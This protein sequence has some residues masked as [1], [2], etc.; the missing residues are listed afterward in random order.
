VGTSTGG[1]IFSLGI[2]YAG[3]GHPGLPTSP[4]DAHRV[5]AFFR[6]QGFDPAP[7]VQ[8]LS[9]A[10]PRDITDRVEEWV[11]DLRL[12]RPGSQIVVFL[13]G[14]GRVH[15]GSHYLLAATSPTGPPY[16][17]TKAVGAEELVRALLNSAARQVLIVLD[18]CHAGFAADQIQAAL[19]KARSAQAGPGIRLA[20][21][22]SCLHHESAYGGQF[23]DAML[24]ALATGSVGRFWADSD[25][26]V[27]PLELCD[28]LRRRLGGEQCALT[29]GNDGM[30]IIPNPLYR[31]DGADRPVEV[32]D[33]FKG[34]PAAEREHFLRKVAGVDPGDVG[35]FFTGRAT[36]SRDVVAWLA[37][38]DQGALVVTG[39]PGAGKSAFLGRLAVLADPD[40]QPAC[41]HLRLLDGDPATRPP[42]GVFDAVVH[43]KNTGVDATAQ[44]VA[45]QIGLDLGSSPAP[46]RDL[47]LALSEQRRRITVL[48]DALD[49]AEHGEEELIARDVLRA[50]AGLD[51]CR[52]IVGT[53]RDRD[54]R[55]QATPGDPGPLITALQ[56]RHGAF[57]VID[58]STD[59]DTDT[60]I[61][62][63]VHDRLTDLADREP[64][65][66]PT[67]TRRA[68]AAREVAAQ[69]QQVFLYARFAL[70]VLTGM[71]EALVEVPGWQSALP[72]DVGHAGLYQV[73]AED[74]R[75]F[76]DPELIREALTP[77]AFARGKGLPRRQIWPELATAISQ[78]FG[79]GRAYH[80]GDIARVI[81]EA[82]WYLIESTEDGQAV[83][84]LYHQA[85]ADYLRHLITNQNT[86]PSTDPT[87]DRATDRPAGIPD[88]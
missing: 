31:A 5:E 65:S 83:Y 63:Y 67:P 34:L 6:Q 19:D 66:W 38:H 58:L 40:S 10:K 78:H 57:T 50:I 88:A 21:L 47:V 71:D 24:D 61:T 25:E 42:V 48:A 23:T 64:G 75:R 59:P 16:F 49:E 36:P 56:P 77:L 39:A 8:A 86:G 26:F 73:F 74:L 28:E 72:G 85:I 87:A 70:R 3:T 13:A 2:D 45:A 17:G 33:L 41:R 53:R 32:A 82:G 69:A 81:R 60:D 51:G 27:E 44:S 37:D 35:W 55:H 54:G 29:A 80:P 68:V 11:D 62:T 1:S 76:D 43:L 14:H 84:R 4:R 12:N 79:S 46:A 18:A 15:D 7:G 30:K 22:T 9:R 20:V 52:V